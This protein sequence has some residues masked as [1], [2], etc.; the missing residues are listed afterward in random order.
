MAPSGRTSGDGNAKDKVGIEALQYVKD[1]RKELITTFIK[2]YKESHPE[3]PLSIFLAGSPG[4][5]KTEYGIS[6]IGGTDDVVRIEADAIREWLPM[7][8][9]AN[10]PLLQQA[11]SRGVDFLFDHLLKHSMSFLLDT[12]FTPW[13]IASQNVGRCLKRKRSVHI[14]YIY[15]DPIVA[16]AFTKKREAVEGRAVPLDSFIHKFMEAHD[17]VRKIISQYGETVDCT[18]VIKNFAGGEKR[19][20]EHIESLEHFLPMQYTVS[21][22]EKLLT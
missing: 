14:H 21:L 6:L 7:Y 5:G 20:F 10:A 4:A 17:N 19:L 1:H 16:W 12:T 22:L 8:N 13:K 15:Q 2:G 9:G 11:A 3:K 18:L